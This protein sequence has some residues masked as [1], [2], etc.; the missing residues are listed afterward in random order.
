MNNIIMNNP[1]HTKKT[2]RSALALFTAFAVVAG[3]VSSAAAQTPTPWPTWPPPQ[4]SPERAQVIKAI[5]GLLRDSVANTQ[6]RDKLQSPASAKTELQ[7]KL[8]PSL[9]LPTKM[10]IVFYEPD[11]PSEASCTVQ[12]KNGLYSV[13]ALSKSPIPT[14]MPDKDVVNTHFMCCYD[15]Y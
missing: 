12:P 10:V 6:L 3:L 5:A 15:P 14:T 11:P 7:N 8:G 1:S 9:L 13:F 2:S 4:G